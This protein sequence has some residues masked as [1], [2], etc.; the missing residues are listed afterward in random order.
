MT[1]RQPSSEDES[2]RRAAALLA[3]ALY[4]IHRSSDRDDVDVARRELTATRI[5]L[6]AIAMR[7]ERQTEEEKEQRLVLAGQLSSL[8]S[9]LERLVG[10]LQG[11]SE[12]VGGLLERAAVAPPGPP[13]PQQPDEP[14]FL[15][16]GEGISV[17]LA[18]VPGFQAL[19]DIQK[20]LLTIE[21]VAGASVERFQEGDSRILLHLRT[22]VTA[23]GLAEALRAATPYAF[24]VEESHPELQRLRL[25]IV[26]TA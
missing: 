8:A 22:P 13:A 1:Q 6:E 5:A 17:A 11:L 12:M 15:P 3:D 16:G 7:I 4:E 23:T 9:S 14:A 10:H 21:A 18:G 2:V 26:P 20:A 24:T 19:M 25:K